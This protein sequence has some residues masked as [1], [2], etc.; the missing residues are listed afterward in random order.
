MIHFSVVKLWVLKCVLQACTEVG[1]FYLINHGIEEKLLEA[2]FSESKKFFSL[3]LEDKMKLA[4]RENRGYSPLYAEILDPSASFK[5]SI[6]LS[7]C[8]F[9][10]TF[11]MFV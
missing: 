6:I 10:A 8:D 5:G 2:V 3:P 11:G 7:H 4:R 9:Y 1:F